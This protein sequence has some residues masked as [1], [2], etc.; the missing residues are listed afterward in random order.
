MGNLMGRLW[1]A[2][3]LLPMCLVTGVRLL[4]VNRSVFGKKSWMWNRGKQG[5]TWSCRTPL[6][7]FVTTCDYKFQKIVGKFCISHRLLLVNSH[8]QLQKERIWGNSSSL[9]KWTQY[10][11]P[12]SDFCFWQCGSLAHTLWGISGRIRKVSKDPLHRNTRT[13]RSGGNEIMRQDCPESRHQ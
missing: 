10:T 5:L 9:T 7:I 8:P 4:L 13:S 2:V 3:W 11:P 12:Q 1:E 6:Y